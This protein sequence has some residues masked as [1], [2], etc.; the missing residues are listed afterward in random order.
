MLESLDDIVETQNNI[1][2]SKS[3]FENS[4]FN[5]N[6]SLKHHDVLKLQV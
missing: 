4:E 3:T 5:K 6:I 2:Y 1:L